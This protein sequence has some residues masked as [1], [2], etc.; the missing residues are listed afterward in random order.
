MTRVFDEPPELGI[1]YRV[2]VYPE[3]A[4]SNLA[5]RLLLRVEV[6]A[7]LDE[8]SAPDEHHAALVHRVS[9]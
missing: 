3:V 9:G 1:G 6:V 7:A 2:D 5:D 8:R 4:D